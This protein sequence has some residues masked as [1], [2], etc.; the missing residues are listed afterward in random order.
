MA[1]LAVF[2]VPE[3]ATF[4]IRWFPPLTA[5]L[6]HIP[7]YHLHVQTTADGYAAIEDGLPI[8]FLSYLGVSWLSADIVPA[9]ITPDDRPYNNERLQASVLERNFSDAAAAMHANDMEMKYKEAIK[10]VN[11][12]R[13]A[14]GKRDHRTEPILLTPSSAFAAAGVPLA[15]L[16][17]LFN[18]VPPTPAQVDALGFWHP[19]DNFDSE[20]EWLVPIEKN[21]FIEFA[22]W[23]RRLNGQFE[24]AQISALP[25]IDPKPLSADQLAK[26]AAIN[27]ERKAEKEQRQPRAPAPKPKPEEANSF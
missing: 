21:L 26:I 8:S 20:F 23:A 2:N 1:N 5:I 6:D 27:E 7:A 25:L 22:W 24:Y 4:D 9:V 11:E 19:G 10:A 15:A 18:N 3:R 14:L 13:K 16:A 12:V 17:P